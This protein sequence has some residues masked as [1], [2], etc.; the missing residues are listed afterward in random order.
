MNKYKDIPCSICFENPN[1]N[2]E[3]HITKC[4]H[5]FHY[6]CIENAI[7][8][9]IME[10]PNCRSNLKT[11]EKKQVIDINNNNRNTINRNNNYNNIFNNILG[12]NYQNNNRIFRNNN[13]LINEESNSRGENNC[14]WILIIF[15]MI[16]FYSFSS[17]SFK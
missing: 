13:N 14:F 7:K 9:D 3:I 12:D 2:D 1:L 17:K 16:L 6:K 8:K 4:E 10:C 15:L 5:I 11:G